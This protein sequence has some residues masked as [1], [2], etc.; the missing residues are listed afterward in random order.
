MYRPMYR[1]LLA[2]N[3]DIRILVDESLIKPLQ[4]GEKKEIRFAKPP[5][6]VVGDDIDFYYGKFLILSGIVTAVDKE[7]ESGWLP[8]VVKFNRVIIREYRFW[9]SKPE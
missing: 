6:F 1:V 3:S 5:P 8:W 2:D 4:N 9:N 7:W